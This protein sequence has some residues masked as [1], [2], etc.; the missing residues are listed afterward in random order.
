MG[1]FRDHFHAEAAGH[2]VEI[3]VR[4]TV[5]MSAEYVLL[6]DGMLGDL[7]QVST[8]HMLM[9][10]SGWRGLVLRASRRSLSSQSLEYAVRGITTRDRLAAQALSRY[11]E[12][13]RS[14]T[15]E[16][17]AFDIGAEI[18]QGWVRT[19]VRLVVNGMPCMMRHLA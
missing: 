11:P 10:I 1:V 19:D 17:D 13:S 2:C 4:M 14:D 7:A 18:L 8:F 6:V 12:K 16:D 9:I 5:W 15:E 3:V